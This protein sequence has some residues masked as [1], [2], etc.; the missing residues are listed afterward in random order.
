[1]SPSRTLAEIRRCHEQSPSGWQ[2]VYLGDECHLK[3]YPPR[4]EG[5]RTAI[6][7]V[8]AVIPGIEQ[9]AIA[10]LSRAHEHVG[11]LLETIDRGIRRV[12]ELESQLERQDGR[13]R[14]QIARTAQAARAATSASTGTG[15]IHAGAQNSSRSGKQTGA[16]ASGGTDAETSTRSEPK[17]NKP[18]DYAAE[19]AM[20]CA[21]PAFRKFLKEQHG[22]ENSTDEATATGVR[23]ICEINSRRELNSAPDKAHIWRRLVNDFEAWKRR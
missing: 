8:C 10:F 1:M 16:R 23:T 11:F 3:A 7:E 2:A 15:D 6:R 9:E 21:D 12:R 17:T 13:Q 4:C 18:K 14:S 20:K 22:L 5:D 19:C